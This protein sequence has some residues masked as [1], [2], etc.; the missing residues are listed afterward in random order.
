MLDNVP[1]LSRQQRNEI[2]GIQNSRDTVANIFGA[3]GTSVQ[4]TPGGIAIT[5]SSGGAKLIQ[6]TGTIADAGPTGQAN[7]TTEVYW[8][9]SL[10][11][12]NPPV[13][14]PTVALK[15]IDS[16]S[17]PSGYFWVPVTNLNETVSH[18]HSLAKGL[19]VSVFGVVVPGGT[20]YY[21][22]QGGAGFIPVL[23]KQNGGMDGAW[24]STAATWTYDIY[25]ISDTGLVT[26]LNSSGALNPTCSRARSMNSSTIQAANGS[27]AMA[28]YD[29]SGAIQIFDLQEFLVQNTCDDSDGGDA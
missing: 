3:N 28:Y 25:A 16:T 6:F 27:L 8:V 26:K 29:A 17:F 7:L 10:A 15:T 20:F 14:T 9:K 13:T 23:V 24:P 2:M 1:F 19:I 18:S 4:H 11:L 22:F 5:Q 12:V 21:M